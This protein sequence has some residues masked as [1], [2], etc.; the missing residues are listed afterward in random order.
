MLYVAFVHRDDEPGFGIRF[1]D[2]PGC[3]A[4]GDTIRRGGTA[5]AFHIEGMIQDG[6]EIPEPR[7]LQESFNEAP[8]G[9]FSPHSHWLTSPVVTLR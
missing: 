6:E 7:S 1:R 5:L 4:D 3:V 9:R 2:F 8:R